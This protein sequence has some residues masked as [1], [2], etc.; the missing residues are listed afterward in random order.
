MKSSVNNILNLIIDIYVMHFLC[1]VFT[2]NM[3][4]FYIQSRCLVNLFNLQNL[5]AGSIYLDKCGELIKAAECFTL[6]GRFKKAAEIYAKG[7]YFT[8]CLSVCTK[9]KCYD[10]GLKYIDSWKQHAC[11]RDNVGKSADEID[12]IRKEFLES[13]ASN[14]FVLKDKESMM[15][16]V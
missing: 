15:K 2:Y 11:Q 13:C 8:E 12:E 4:K 9:G 6:A 14:S 16:F 7:N 10:L 1:D 5:Y 3:R